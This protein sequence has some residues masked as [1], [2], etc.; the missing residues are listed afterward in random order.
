MTKE[1]PMTN[2]Q[3]ALTTA[4]AAVLVKLWALGLGSKGFSL[5]LNS[6]SVLPR[7]E[8]GLVA[9]VGR[10]GAVRR[11]E[12]LERGKDESSTRVFTTRCHDL[13][14]PGG[15]GEPERSFSSEFRD[16]FPR[17]PRN[18][19]SR[20]RTTRTGHGAWRTTRSAV[21]PRTAWASPLRPCVERTMRS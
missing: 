19:C 10:N 4:P 11:L 9:A 18:S 7:G 5:V 16:A 3:A 6:T 12:R 2:D 21:L 20:A 1:C 8:G 14:L 13:P 17:Y 15:E